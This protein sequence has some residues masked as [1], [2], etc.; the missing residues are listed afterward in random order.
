MILFAPRFNTLREVREKIDCGMFS[1]RFDMR[2]SSVIWWKFERDGESSVRQFPIRSTL[3]A[4]QAEPKLSGRVFS[5]MLQR[6][7]T[8]SFS[9]ELL[10]KNFQPFLLFGTNPR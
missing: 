1:S 9:F 8:S 2:T 4:E 7:N 10:E 3:R 6:S 5:L